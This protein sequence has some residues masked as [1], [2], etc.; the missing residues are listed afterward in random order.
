MDLVGGGSFINGA[1]PSSFFIAM[2]REIPKHDKESL[3]NEGLRLN[4]LNKVC[5]V[6]L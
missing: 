3:C 5:S 2:A 1:T 6:Y 4:I